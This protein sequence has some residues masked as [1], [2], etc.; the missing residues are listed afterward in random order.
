M[1]FISFRP[2][3]RKNCREV[4]MDIQFAANE[5]YT[6]PNRCSGFNPLCPGQ[7]MQLVCSIMETLN[8]YEQWLLVL[9]KVILW[10]SVRIICTTWN[11]LVPN[12]PPLV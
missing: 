6:K 10:H 11:T 3:P 12:G 4:L 7:M 5:T 8:A 9:N 1:V 2:T